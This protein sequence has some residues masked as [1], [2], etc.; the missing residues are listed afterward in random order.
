MVAPNWVKP[1][2]EINLKQTRFLA[3]QAL[4]EQGHDRRRSLYVKSTTTTRIS[5]K[6]LTRAIV[7]LGLSLPITSHDLLYFGTDSEHT[8]LSN[9]SLCD[10]CVEA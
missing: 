9:T 4:T 3:P 6:G 2:I 1:T 7:S 5:T 10:H 8:K